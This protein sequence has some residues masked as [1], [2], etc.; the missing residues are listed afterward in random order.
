MVLKILQINLQH[1]RA[2]SAALHTTLDE[3]F[4]DVAL[5]QEPWIDFNGN[6]KG[7]ASRTYNLYHTQ[8]EGKKRSAILVRKDLNAFLNPKHS[9]MDLTTVVLRDKSGKT[10]KIASSYMAHNLEAPPED[11]RRLIEEVT[12][13]NNPLV[14]GCDANAHNL[15]WGSTDT[16]D[17]GE[18]LLH[19]INNSILNIGNRGNEPTFIGATSKNVLDLTLVSDNID[20][21]QL[22]W[23]VLEKVSFSDHKYITFNVS[24]D[25]TSQKAFRNP[26]KTNWE[27]F[28]KIASQKLKKIKNF[29]INGPMDVEF[30]INKLTS[31]INCAY[32]AS[33]PIM[34]PKNQSKPPWWNKE[35]TDNR[36]FIQTLFKAARDAECPSLWQYYRVEVKKFKKLVRKAKRS[37]WKSFCEGIEKTSE[38]SRLRKILSKKH[39]HP[40]LLQKDGGEWNVNPEEALNE[41]IDT[42]FPGSIE[43]ED[44]YENNDF[45]QNLQSTDQIFTE[46][47]IE[48]A[49]DSFQ[50]FKSPGEDGIFPAFVQ[51]LKPLI[52]KLLTDIYNGCVIYKVVPTQWQLS[53]VVFI[54]KGGKHSH[55]KAKDFR[56]ISLT[57]FFLKIMERALDLIIK[58]GL[59][60]TYL[61]KAQ[62]AYQKGKST[63][64]ALHVAVHY[65][66]SSLQFKEYTLC[67]S[68]DIEGAFNNINTETI[69]SA[70]RLAG[71]QQRIIDWI[72]V[73]L[74]NRIIA[75]EW[76]Q[77]KVRKKVTR[78]TPQG[79]VLSPLLWILAI[80]P[81]LETLS[82]QGI[83]VVA[84]ADDIMLLTS[85]KCLNTLRDLLQSSLNYTQK[86]TSNC[87]LNLNPQKTEIILFT[88]KYKPP[89]LKEIK[90]REIT[91]PLTKQIK[92][93]G[94]ILDSKLDWKLNISERVKKAY[95]AY[96]SC[97]RMFSRRWGLSP[98]VTH[99][100]Y[101][102]IVRPI[103]LY[104]IVVWWQ[105]LEIKT[106]RLKLERVQ[107]LMSL[108]T[109][110]ALKSTSTNSLNTILHLLP[111][112][113]FAKDVAYR[114]ALRLKESNGFKIRPYG[115]GNIENVQ[116]VITD[117]KKPS[118]NVS[119]NFEIDL[120]SRE[121][122]VLRASE[123]PDEISVFTDGSKTDEG[124][125]AGFFIPSTDVRQSFKLPPYCSVFQ[126]EIE[127]IYQACR[128]LN[129]C[130]QLQITF[131]TDSQAAIKALNKYST[132]SKTVQKCYDAL[133]NLGTCNAVKVC[134]VP[135]HQGI[136]GN[137]EADDLAKQGTKMDSN[138]LE[139]PPPI[140]HFYNQNYNN[141]IHKT[142]LQWKNN[143]SSS[144][145]K[146]F[147][148]CYDSKKTEFLLSLPRRE[149][150]LLVGITTGHC[151]I[152]KYAKKIGILTDD[153]CRKCKMLDTIESIDHIMCH[154]PA[155]AKTRARY[156]GKH[157]FMNLEEV[158]ATHLSS[159]KAFAKA[160]NIF[161]TTIS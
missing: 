45:D 97:K 31:I 102:S 13:D 69:V 104:G 132:T 100:I 76:G 22:S 103:L 135:G 117:Y 50:P 107:R 17:R 12:K 141:L 154:C 5:I 87:G 77:I 155:L 58:N 43:I 63:E 36:S 95:I 123:I 139:V 42:H 52:L 106:N 91:I 23:K 28:V 89:Q 158:A 111:I 26:E 49:I 66:E 115:H 44:N 51:K 33:C 128:S 71:V 136:S 2:A 137:E 96:Y 57:S 119:H 134:W 101:T 116:R 8:L 85:G 153:S 140:Q 120:P 129:N 32:K 30:A 105:A 147:W 143:N 65:I 53:R 27:K 55:T 144:V 112:E 37:S 99:W 67:G 34:R 48:Y 64:T 47:V 38:T 160:I 138:L 159:I 149:C 54:P 6:V 10:L 14:I 108:C 78:G 80:N 60:T 1:S 25:K 145:T 46:S 110:A 29:Q 83:D 81:L 21:D 61:S 18:S 148:P 122:W 40:T 39:I 126:A 3:G 131:F 9:S 146:I 24:F 94:I 133:Q 93:L 125:G 152:A 68:L 114:T 130:T 113:T 151:L 59:S 16:N 19:F 121:Q 79:G 142:N 88:R 74:K 15:L 72:E 56:P 4:Y 35:L 118:N 82:L 127:A 109:T 20:L 124:T 75:A 73:L 157:F 70:L 11:V 90:I 86:W 7:L 98:K 62:H 161:P 41:L 92:F 156:L 84:Y 150:G